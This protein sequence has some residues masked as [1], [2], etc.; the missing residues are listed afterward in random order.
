MV[1]GGK[2]TSESGSASSSGSSC[3]PFI[4][5]HGVGTRSTSP[6]ESA[7]LGEH[8]DRDYFIVTV[9]ELPQLPSSDEVVGTAS[10]SIVLSGGKYYRVEIRGVEEPSRSQRRRHK[11][12]P[13]VADPLA[14]AIAAEKNAE[15]FTDEDGDFDYVKARWPVDIWQLAYGKVVAPIQESD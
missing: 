14:A 13:F 15:E 11:G 6:L 1:A 3:Y 7:L 9:L 2:N 4:A 10:L 8:G 12:K 5:V